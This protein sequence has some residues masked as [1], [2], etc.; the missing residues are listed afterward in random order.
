[1]NNITR[2]AAITKF[3]IKCVVK[4][5]ANARGL[6][7]YDSDMIE[8]YLY[9]AKFAIQDREAQRKQIDCDDFVAKIFTIMAQSD[10]VCE[11]FNDAIGNVVPNAWSDDPA[12]DTRREL[13]FGDAMFKCF[14][15]DETKKCIVDQMKVYIT[16][17]NLEDFKFATT[18]E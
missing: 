9:R 2:Q 1:M 17:N 6:W 15:S 12:S 8:E 11:K 13:V 5:E 7:S 4:A 16:C 10:E 3:G 14:T 18:A